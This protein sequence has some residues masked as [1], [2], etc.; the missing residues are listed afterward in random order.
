MPFSGRECWLLG[1]IQCLIKEKRMKLSSKTSQPRYIFL[2]ALQFPSFL[3][4][5]AHR[6]S[7]CSTLSQSNILGK[8]WTSQ[9]CLPVR[10]ASFPF[11]TDHDFFLLAVNDFT[12][13]RSFYPVAAWDK[14][15]LKHKDTFWLS[16]HASELVVGWLEPVIFSHR[17][18]NGTSVIRGPFNYDCCR[19]SQPLLPLFHPSSLQLSYNCDVSSIARLSPRHS[20]QQR[21]ALRHLASKW[22]H[23]RIPS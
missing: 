10:F 7:A 20:Y 19:I 3:D 8:T 17:S 22:F 14:G 2:I 23:F 15:L 18:I 13:P 4:K 1:I 12:K 21:F 11:Y 6:K 9:F 5:F 16:Y